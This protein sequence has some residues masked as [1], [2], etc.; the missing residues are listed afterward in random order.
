MKRLIAILL[1]IAVAAGA[2]LAHRR[3]DCLGKGE[4]KVAVAAVTSGYTPWQTVEISGKLHADVL[5][6]SPTVK[7][8]ME[9]GKRVM[10][11]L[12]APLLG[13]VGRLEA[14]KDSILVVNKMKKTYVKEST[15]EM[16][17]GFPVSI[18]DLQ[19][20]FLARIAV[21]GTGTLSTHNAELTDFYADNDGGWMIVPSEKVQPNGANYGYLT[22]ADG[23]LKAF[24]AVPYGGENTVTVLYEYYGAAVTMLM[25]IELPKKPLDLEFDLD[26]PNWN[27]DAFGAIKLNSK[28]KRMTLK[29]FMKSF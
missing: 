16:Q 21:G 26:T 23:K 22:S 27:A 24:M 17:S 14:D 25:N 28:Y 5:P 11:S 2:A 15:A 18:A 10:V 12:R 8:F 9:N 7:I 20:L 6:L 13:E 3:D 4:K 1:T 29:N 19:S